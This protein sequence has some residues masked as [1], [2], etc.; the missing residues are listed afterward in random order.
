VAAACASG[1]C[2]AALGISIRY[3]VTNRASATTTMFI[4]GSVG[5]VGLLIGAYWRI[6]F[7]GMAATSG[8]ALAAM[9][10]AGFFNAVSFLAMTKA[11]QLTNV[12]YAYALNAT[13][14]TMGAL[15]GVIFF[16]EATTPWLGIGVLLTIAGLLHMRRR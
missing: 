16:Q 2:F 1:V 12:A 9:L 8:P 11:L 15:A 3:G 7:D 13:Q 10:A 5:F 6:G 4:V 14:A